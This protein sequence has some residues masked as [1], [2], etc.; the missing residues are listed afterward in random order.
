MPGLLSG[1]PTRHQRAT[2]RAPDSLNPTPPPG[3][4]HGHRVEARRF[5]SLLGVATCPGNWLRLCVQTIEISVGCASH[6]QLIGNAATR[7]TGG[8]RTSG[9]QKRSSA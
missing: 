3:L 2:A 6:V 1:G 8:S 4:P 9:R 7:L 5:L